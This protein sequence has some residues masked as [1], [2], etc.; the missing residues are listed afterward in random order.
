L[1][2][3][4]HTGIPSSSAADRAVSIPSAIPGS[5]HGHGAS[6]LTNVGKRVMLL[7]GSSGQSLVD[8]HMSGGLI[9]VRGSR[10][11]DLP[12]LLRNRPVRF[13]RVS[14]DG[15]LCEVLRVRH[16]FRP[17]RRR[18]TS[19]PAPLSADLPSTP[20]CSHMQPGISFPP[21]ARQRRWQRH[22]LP[23]RLAPIGSLHRLLR[24]HPTRPEYPP[25]LLRKHYELAC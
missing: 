3:A 22:L 1:F 7:I 9:C 14:S 21:A 18:D 16:I 24:A 23:L 8:C 19:V 5:V 6:P 10:F 20:H 12:N 2:R 4:A 17:S 13:L 15:K 25:L 11:R